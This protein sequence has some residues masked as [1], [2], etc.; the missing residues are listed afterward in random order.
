MLL[1]SP[2]QVQSLSSSSYHPLSQTFQRCDYE[3][4]LSFLSLIYKHHKSSESSV[5][6]DTYRLV[7]VHTAYFLDKISSV[8]TESLHIVFN[9]EHLN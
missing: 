2:C 1:P 8:F 9:Y 7:K 5:H 3:G 4:T 6:H